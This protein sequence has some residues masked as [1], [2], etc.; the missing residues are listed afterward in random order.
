MQRFNHRGTEA[1]EGRFAVG[2]APASAEIS[3]P[4]PLLET[5]QTVLLVSGD[6]LLW[7]GFPA[8]LILGSR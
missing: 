4:I 7:I 1:A 5:R 8:A 6:V 3:G 2:G